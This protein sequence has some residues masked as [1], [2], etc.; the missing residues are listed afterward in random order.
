MKSAD[1]IFCRIANGDIPSKTI[2]EDNEFRVILD[3]SPATKG[4]ALILPKKHYEDIYELDEE[5]AKKIFVLAKD[6]SVKM[7]DKLKCA[8]LNIVQNNG[9][10]AGQTVFHFHMHIIPRYKDDRQYIGWKQGKPTED[11]LEEVRKIIIN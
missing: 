2:Y 3:L 9:E 11:E 8:G 4:H 1:C 6:L 5:L 10:M 7:K